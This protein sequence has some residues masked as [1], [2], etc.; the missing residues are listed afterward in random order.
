MTSAKLDAAGYWWLAALSTFNFSIQYRAGKKN[1]D[2]DGLY[3]RPHDQV[4][5]DSSSKVEDEC[6]KEFIF[7]F[8]KEENKACFPHEAVKA[9]CQKHQLYSGDASAIPTEFSQAEFLPRS[10]TLPRMLQQDWAAEQA[11][12]PVISRVTHLLNV[13]KRLSY[14]VKQQEPRE[15]Q[16]MLRLM[17]QL[18]VMDGVLYRKRMNTGE[19]LYQLVLPQKYREVAL[20]ALHDLVGHMGVELT[21]D[22]VRTRFY[23]PTL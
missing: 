11:N 13:G 5:T 14:R 9:V 4:D 22:L 7:R 8:L 6:I 3:R 10:S 20:E 17:D 19:P 16:L 2:A 1:Q 18:V 23:W 21:L 12:D 15:V